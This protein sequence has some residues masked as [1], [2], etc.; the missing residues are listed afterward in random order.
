MKNKKKAIIVFLMAAVLCLGV[1]FAALA[2]DL[3][4]TGPLKWAPG[5]VAEAEINKSVYFKDVEQTAISIVDGDA[6]TVDKSKVTAEAGGTENRTLTITVGETTFSA[7]QQSVKIVATI[8]S[9]YASELKVSLVLSGST[10]NTSAATESNSYLN[11]DLNG[12]VL[13]LDHFKIT[14]GDNIVN[15]PASTDGTEKTTEVSITIE[16]TSVPA[17]SELQTTGDDAGKYVDK[18]FK[19]LLLAEPA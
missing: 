19:L 13:Q 11:K 7:A 15:I 17:N 12:R 18:T 3:T 10:A 6:T 5:P 14:I 1:G 9:K 4:L 8:A 2:T 16:L